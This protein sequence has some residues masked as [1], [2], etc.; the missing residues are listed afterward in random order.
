MA[1]RTVV[2]LAGKGE[3]TRRLYHALAG[4]FAIARVVMEEPVPAWQFFRRRAAKYGWR[5]V[6]GQV[7]FIVF[8]RLVLRPG[9]RRR[10]GEIHASLGLDRAAIDPEKVTEVASCNA[11]ETIALLQALRPGVVVI[12]GTRIVSEKVLTSVPAR[13]INMHAGVTPLY[14]GAHGAYWA[15]VNGDP[16]HCGVTVHLV[17]PGIDTGG[18]LYQARI[19]PQAADNITTYPILQQAAGLPLMKRA[20]RDVFDGTVSVQQPPAGASR[21]W[22]HP[23]LFEYLFYR[24]TRRVK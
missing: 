16:A 2:L 15:L 3:S 10:A 18:V 9:A 14:R 20:I 24:I 7:L 21:L 1:E 13:F 4:E 19:Q 12:N 5:R 11:A 22:A 17:D 23:T 6:F 8:A